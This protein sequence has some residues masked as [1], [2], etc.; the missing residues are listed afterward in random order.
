[1]CR[2]YVHID[3]DVKGSQKSVLDPLELELQLAT[4]HPVWVLGAK[5]GPSTRAV[6]ILNPEPSLQPVFTYFEPR[7]LTE[8][9]A[10]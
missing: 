5:L 6:Y 9:G 1:M 7:S 8:S 10:H 4:R 2:G 3:E